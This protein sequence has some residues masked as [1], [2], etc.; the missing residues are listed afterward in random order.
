MKNGVY[1]LQLLE[2]MHLTVESYID[3]PDFVKHVTL[4]ESLFR[5]G[6]DLIREINKTLI[7]SQRLKEVYDKLIKSQIKYLQKCHL[8]RYNI[9]ISNL[10]R[11]PHDEFSLII[12]EEVKSI[13]KHVARIGWEL[14]PE[15]VK[16]L[17]AELV[18][19]GFIDGE[20]CTLVDFEPR[21]LNTGKIKGKIRW[22]K[23]LYQLVR[24]FSVLKEN[25]ILP[26]DFTSTILREHFNDKKGRPIKFNTLRAQAQSCTPDIEKKI[27]KIVY[28][29]LQTN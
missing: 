21:F 4:I 27:S 26:E 10:V 25:K 15:K 11:E 17:Y 24:L 7:N 14:N 3:Q 16:I 18:K 9:P 29:L 23:K 28:L 22:C 6:F 8:E 19:Y 20:E 2:Q 1:L 5:K 13:S 12:N